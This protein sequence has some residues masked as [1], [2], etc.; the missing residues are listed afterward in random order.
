MLPEK[1]RLKIEKYPQSFP[2]HKIYQ[3]INNN[4]YGE[5]WR[6]NNN[7]LQK[8]KTWVFI[9]NQTLC[10]PRGGRPSIQLLA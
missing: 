9:S 1:I 5:T 3:S 2:Q 7:Q 8:N 4:H 10:I 6:N